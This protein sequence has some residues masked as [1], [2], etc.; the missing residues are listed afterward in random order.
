MMLVVSFCS[1]I[2]DNRDICGEVSTMQSTN[3]LKYGL[4][5]VKRKFFRIKV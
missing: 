3:L 4:T 1:R 2:C 5:K